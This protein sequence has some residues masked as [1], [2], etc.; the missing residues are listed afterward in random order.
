ML[1]TRYTIN[2]IIMIIL[3]NIKINIPFK[4]GLA[5]KILVER[6]LFEKRMMYTATLVIKR[7]FKPWLWGRT[8]SV[9][10]Q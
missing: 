8:C 2:I 1:R 3:D 5:E 4:K 9:L 7:L 6:R 10:R